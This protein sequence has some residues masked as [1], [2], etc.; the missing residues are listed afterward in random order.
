MMRPLVYI[1]CLSH[2]CF[3]VGFFVFKSK[4][5]LNARKDEGA[6]ATV[7]LWTMCSIF[8]AKFLQPNLMARS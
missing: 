6:Q 4:G 2:M 7:P 3:R 8:A 5:L 1:Y